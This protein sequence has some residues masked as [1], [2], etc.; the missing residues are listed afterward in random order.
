MN[1]NVKLEGFLLLI[2]LLTVIALVFGFFNDFSTGSDI[3]LDGGGGSGGGSGAGT[4]DGGGSG[5]GDNSEGGAGG[6]SGGGNTGG[7]NGPGSNI[8]SIS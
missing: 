5:S 7:A 1:K 2:I 8:I 4:G 3:V 6:G